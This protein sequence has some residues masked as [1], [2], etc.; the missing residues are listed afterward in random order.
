MYSDEFIK[1][2]E[3]RLDKDKSEFN[4]RP[5]LFINAFL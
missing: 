1:M 5:E 4:L 3:G 2:L